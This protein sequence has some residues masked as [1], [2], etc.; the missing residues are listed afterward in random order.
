V[1]TRRRRL[2]SRVRAAFPWLVLVGI[3]VSL[4]VNT[5]RP[6]TNTDTYFH[7]R[8][9]HEFLH[10]WSVRHPGSVSTFA[11]ADWVPTQWLS[12]IGMAKTE[13]WFGLPG[14]AWLSG[15][16]EVLLF[17]GVYAACRVR[18]EPLVAMP[19][20]ALSLY[21]M[22]AGLSMRP[23]VISYL[24]TA[25]VVAAWLRTLDDGRVRWWLVPLVWLWA[26]LHGMW[27]IAILVGAVSTVGLVLDRTPR[28]VVVRSALLTAGCAVAAAVTPIGPALYGAV[29]AVGDRRSYFAEW[30]PPDWTSWPS[31]AF[32]VLLAATLVG[33]WRRRE[34]PWTESMLIVLAG[35]FAAYSERTVPVGAAMLAPLAAGPIQALV[36]RRMPVS[37]GE[38]RAVL[39]S[40]ALAVAVLA[41]LVPYTSDDPIEVPAWADTAIGS[42]PA[43]T[44]VIDDWDLGGYLMWR[45][46]R[47]DLVMHGYGDT[48]TTA[49]LDR[50]TG[51]MQVKPG[52]QADVVATGARVALLRPW[53]ALA[54]RL[55]GEEGW[56]VEHRS[57]SLELLRAPPDWP[58]TSPPVAPVGSFG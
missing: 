24:L 5:A 37:L 33:L 55:V 14:V 40:A 42:L 13:D 28:P 11:T 17:L 54:Q 32:A 12:E 23:Q 1:P 41:V 25:V 34:N 35:V 19:V 53:S 49:E 26:L 4:V 8:F 50:N 36:G 30:M 15:L 29:L 39:G 31:A 44:K 10:G 48:F 16:L 43:G 7:L 18:A 6:L 3:L 20:T 21:A 57:A 9:G 56:S 38:R 27:P 47:L 52:W 2:W 46:P 45:Y 51:F 22:Q 58:A